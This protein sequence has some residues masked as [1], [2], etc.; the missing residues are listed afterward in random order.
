MVCARQ[1]AAVCLVQAAEFPFLAV[2]VQNHDVCW[3][4]F[5]QYEGKMVL[6]WK[7]HIASVHW[8][9]LMFGKLSRKDASSIDYA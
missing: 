6:S 7:H 3:V 5:K 8:Y 9:K 4:L 2:F 1:P